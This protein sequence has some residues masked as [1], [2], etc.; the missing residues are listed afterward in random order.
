MTDKK[1]TFEEA[2]QKWLKE[3]VK[4][5]GWEEMM[6]DGDNEMGKIGERLLNDPEYMKIW[7]E[8]LKGK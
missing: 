1:M 5:R 6:E 3:H 2:K 4:G 7:E 8:T